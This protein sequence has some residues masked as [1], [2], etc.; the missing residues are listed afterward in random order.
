MEGSRYLN[1]ADSVHYLSKSFGGIY[2]VQKQA[3]IQN[4]L[5]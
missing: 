4:L 2:E 3:T 5:A 1:L